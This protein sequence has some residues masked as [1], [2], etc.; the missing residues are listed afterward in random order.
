MDFLHA[1]MMESLRIMPLSGFN[2]G[3]VATEDH[4]IGDIKVEKGTQI[5][6][7]IITKH[8]MPSLYEDPEV[9]KPERFL[10]GK[11]GPKHPMGFMTFSQ[12][13]HSCIGR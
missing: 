2:V 8:Y 13:L 12:G 7:D 11:N 10:E 9:F 3:S 5:R 1:I 6:T 4:M